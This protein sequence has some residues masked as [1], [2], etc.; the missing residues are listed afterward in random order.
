MKKIKDMVALGTLAGL[1]GTIPQIILNFILTQTGFSQY[2]SFQLSGSVYLEKPLTYTFWGM[3]LGGLVWEFMAAGLGIATAYF[4]NKMGKDFWWLKGIMVSNMIM[5]IF[6]YGFFFSLEAPK[7]VPWDLGTNWGVLVE[8]LLFGITT[9][10]VIVRR[11][12]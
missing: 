3:V 1:I 10:W 4:I 11:G 2:Y 6:I 8:N 5:F 12:E 7:I 9:S